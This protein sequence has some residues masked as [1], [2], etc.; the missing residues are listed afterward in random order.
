[1]I[2]RWA[3][4]LHSDEFNFVQSLPHICITNQILSYVSLFSLATAKIA[5][6]GANSNQVGGLT[7]WT[8]V[9]TVASQQDISWFKSQFFLCGVCIFSPCVGG[10]SPAMGLGYLRFECE[11]E[12]LSVSVCWPCNKLETCSGCTPASLLSPL[13]SLDYDLLRRTISKYVFLVLTGVCIL[14]SPMHIAG[15]ASIP[16]GSVVQGAGLDEKVQGQCRSLSSFIF[17]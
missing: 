17:N 13:C 8:V 2:N 3:L 12:W 5:M 6:A 1:M 4:P 14:L 16:S 11:C 9:T 10:S 15:L 7:Q